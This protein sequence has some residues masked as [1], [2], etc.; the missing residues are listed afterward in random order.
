MRQRYIIIWNY[1]CFI[2][3][4]AFIIRN[5]YTL[6]TQNRLIVVNHLHKLLFFYYFCNKFGVIL[7]F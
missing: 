1:K 5:N 6:H 4:Y 2:L 3:N 7:P